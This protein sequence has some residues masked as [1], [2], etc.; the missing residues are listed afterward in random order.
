MVHKNYSQWPRLCDYYDRPQIQTH[1]PQAQ[2]WQY[3]IAPTVNIL[4]GV[5]ESRDPKAPLW[6]MS[7]PLWSANKNGWG[8]RKTSWNASGQ[9]VMLELMMASNRRKGYWEFRIDVWLWTPD[10]EPL[11]HGRRDIPYAGENYTWNYVW[12]YPRRFN[13]E[14]W[15]S[16]GY[17]TEIEIFPTSPTHAWPEVPVNLR[18]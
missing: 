18:N 13:V 7:Q 17:T 5:Q 12:R 3:S 16:P 6:K 1:W 9:D 10:Y 8:Y 2:G 14:S 15:Y 11:A 4:F